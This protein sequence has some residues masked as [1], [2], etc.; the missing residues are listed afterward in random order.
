M[1]QTDLTVPVVA[2]RHLNLVDPQ[3]RC[4]DVPARGGAVDIGFP[5]LGSS[6][7]AYRA[8]STRPDS[9]RALRLSGTGVRLGDT[10]RALLGLR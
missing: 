10:L 9:N 2:L 8:R 3:Q 6:R 5:H 7:Q 1:T 4:G